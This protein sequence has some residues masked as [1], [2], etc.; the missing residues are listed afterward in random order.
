MHHLIEPHALSHEVSTYIYLYT[1]IYIYIH[2]YI[3][4]YICI[5]RFMIRYYDSLSLCVEDKDEI[6]PPIAQTLTTGNRIF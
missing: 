2:I 3:Y 4:I 5:Y 6:I 1:Y